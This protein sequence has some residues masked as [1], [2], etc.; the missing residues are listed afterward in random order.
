MVGCVWSATCK[1]LDWLN[2]V[3]CYTEESAGLLNGCPT[4]HETCVDFG[5]VGRIIKVAPSHS[6]LQFPMNL[7]RF[8]RG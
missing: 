6:A 7:C 2:L 5:D 4:L 8:I 1:T 3:F